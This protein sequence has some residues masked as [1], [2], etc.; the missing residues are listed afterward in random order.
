MAQDA[1]TAQ[2][3]SQPMT[4][5][6]QLN[7]PDW[8]AVPA[9][10]EF[11]QFRPVAGGSPD[12]DTAVRVLFD[13][14]FVYVGVRV[15]NTQ[16]PPQA[17]ISQREDINDDDQIGIYID[18]VGDGRS[19]YIFY[20][21]AL[22]IQQDIRYSN[23]DWFSDWDTV[24]FSQGTVTEDGY[25]L[26]VAIPF[27]SL[28]YPAAE[29][30]NW[31]LMF[32]RKIPRVG[33][34]YGWPEMARRHPRPFVQARPM[35][36]LEVPN[37][38]A[39]LSIQPSL[40]GAQQWDT[41]DSESLQTVNTEQ[42]NDQLR[43]SINLQWGYGADSGLTATINPDFS[44]IE[45][46]VNQVN[47]NARFAFYY[48]E[49]R[50]FFLDNIGMF[51]DTSS[52][53]YTRSI[54]DPIYGLKAAGTQNGLDYGLLHSIDRN[55]LASFNLNETPG[56]SDDDT[57]GRWASTTVMRLRKSA[58]GQGFVGLYFSDKRLLE[59]LEQ[60][61][62]PLDLG[63]NNVLS[64]D[65]NL[66]FS[67]VWTL[68]AAHNNSV[69]N[70][71]EHRL[72]GSLT[73]MVIERQP[74]TGFGGNIS[75]K[76]STP[77]YRNETGFVTLSGATT[78]S[79][80]LNYGQAI[81]SSFIRPELEFSYT[82]EEIG[83]HFAGL[84]A[85]TRININGLHRFQFSYGPR[86]VH[87]Q[88]VTVDGYSSKAEWSARFSQMLKTKVGVRINREIDYSL[89]I[90]GISQA[91]YFE[92]VLR[93]SQRLKIFSELSHSR[94]S[95]EGL[96]SE[97][98]NNLFNKLNYQM[99]RNWGLRLIQQSTLREDELSTRNSL[100]F[101]WIR[102]PGTEAYIGGTLSSSDST[103]TEASLF[104]K[105]TWLFRI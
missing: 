67:E 46:D 53:L 4:I 32:T 99:T 98:A 92:L 29:T 44:Q 15:S 52:S 87:F 102:S 57:E 88:D 8:Q 71:N 33:A 77:G 80:E 62:S 48:P 94:F 6:G 75:L 103:L 89:K 40:F 55:P 104:A 22:G 64:L 38:G 51:S 69:T 45:G 96:G 49:Q 73:S 11:L 59:P 54:A 50:A 14:R 5:D 41:E 13:D 100:L 65:L 21:N 18:T 28:R 36:G 37:R 63:S 24:Y 72:I 3:T 76:H 93:P 84:D 56:F 68:N 34:K 85:S 23:G 7:E 81:G 2:R 82:E 27:R 35:V 60:A 97:L 30:P 105:L 70:A 42:L 83:N 74:G 86:L 25:V 17:R 66:P 79:A 58:F 101:T 95:P 12:G 91:P 31:K 19:G 16:H 43:P 39:G 78:T 9:I 47:V 90:P 10:T 1:V 20:I 26:E 61:D